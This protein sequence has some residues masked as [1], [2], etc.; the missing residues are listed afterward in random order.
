MAEKKIT[1][2]H[3]AEK[4][5]GTK[6][7]AAKKSPAKKTTSKVAPKEQPA[8]SKST[9][10]STKEAVKATESAGKE[11]STA[12]K[13]SEKKKTAAA[14]KGETVTVRLVKS[15]IGA[16]AKQRGTVRGLGLRKV[17]SER[18]LEDTP[19]VRGMVRKIQHMVQVVG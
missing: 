18:T 13:A 5:E 7:T 10:K 16:L 2:E 12:S 9:E 6:K 14:S 11:K 8:A 3:K 15:P 17:G 1:D 19:A 4:A